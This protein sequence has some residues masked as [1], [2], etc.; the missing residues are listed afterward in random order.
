MDPFGWWLIGVL[1]LAVIFECGR[2][3]GGGRE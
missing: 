1:A 2:L 3:A